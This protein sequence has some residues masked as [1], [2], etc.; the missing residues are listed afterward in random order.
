MVQGAYGRHR[1]D[2]FLLRT[3]TELNGACRHFHMAWLYYSGLGV[4]AIPLS[5]KPNST[6]FCPLNFV[7]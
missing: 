7:D 6:P 4:N 3:D 2:A 5:I 1:I